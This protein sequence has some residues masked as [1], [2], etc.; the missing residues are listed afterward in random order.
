MAFW[1]DWSFFSCHLEL[2]C[3]YICSCGAWRSNITYH[4]E[5][6]EWFLSVQKRPK[7]MSRDKT[8][9]DRPNILCLSCLVFYNKLITNF[10]NFLGK[11]K[12][13]LNHYAQAKRAKNS[14]KYFISWRLKICKRLLIGYKVILL[15]RRRFIIPATLC[16]YFGRRRRVVSSS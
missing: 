2:W 11:I 13:I 6:K 1:T 10:F 3:S 5:K 8:N 7:N 9:N 15:S 16:S 12:Y 4:T 14:Q